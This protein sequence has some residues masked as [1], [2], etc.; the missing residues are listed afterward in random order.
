VT[1]VRADLGGD[2]EPQRIAR[3]KFERELAVFKADSMR[4][5][6]LAPVGPCECCRRELTKLVAGASA[7]LCATCLPFSRELGW[8]DDPC[9]CGTPPPSPSPTEPTA[10]RP[11]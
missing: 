4:A 5:E 3:N 6:L 1:E 2:A 10:S 11:F 8:T 9:P 7:F